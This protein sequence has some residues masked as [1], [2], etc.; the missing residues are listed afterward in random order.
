MEPPDINPIRDVGYPVSCDT[1]PLQLLTNRPPNTGEE[2]GGGHTVQAGTLDPGNNRFIQVERKAP[3][4]ELARSGVGRVH[5]HQAALKW[6]FGEDKGVLEP[7]GIIIV[8]FEVPRDLVP[9]VEQPDDARPLYQGPASKPDIRT[10]WGADRA[11]DAF[12]FELLHDVVNNIGHARTVGK[13]LGCAD[14][15]PHAGIP[16]TTQTRSPVRSRARPA[17]ITLILGWGNAGES[18]H[19]LPI[20]PVPGRIRPRS[21]LLWS[22]TYTAPSMRESPRYPIPDPAL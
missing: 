3:H 16:S 21:L 5:R 20:I 18:G 6:V 8:V 15:Q 11:L 14:E 10:L 2:S 19:P 7:G 13:V 17:A 9:V 12:F 22:S 1:D 4:P